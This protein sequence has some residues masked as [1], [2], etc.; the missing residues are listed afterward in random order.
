M[1]SG[2]RPMVR[3]KLILQ[4]LLRFGR[5]V[6]LRVSCWILFGP[7]GRSRVR[8][9]RGPNNIVTSFLL[10]VRPDGLE[11]DGVGRL[12]PLQGQVEVSRTRPVYRPRTVSCDRFLRCCRARPPAR[13]AASPVA[14][15]RPWGGERVPNSLPRERLRA[16]GQISITKTK[17]GTLGRRATWT[18]RKARTVCPGG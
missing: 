6:V 13:N 9:G 5:R 11:P 12:H 4:R 18:L 8:Q 17:R 15:K 7:V 2:Y 16:R 1:P 14:R 10:P 3:V